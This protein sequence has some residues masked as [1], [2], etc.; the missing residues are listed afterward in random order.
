[1]L[2]YWPVLLM[3]KLAIFFIPVIFLFVLPGCNKF[4]YSPYQTEETHDDLPQNLNNSNISKLLQTEAQADDTVTFLYAG[5]SQRFYEELDDLVFKVN[6]IPHVDFFILCG[7]MTDFGIIKEYQ[8]IYRGLGKL[9]VPYMC[10][11]GNHDLTGGG[12]K[13]YTSMFGVKNFSF[14]YKTYKFIFHDTNS[15]EYGFNGAV[16]DINWLSSELADP[17]AGWF[18]GVSHVPPYDSD[19]DDALE[20]PYRTLFAD[21]SNFVVSLHGHTHMSSD[22]YVYNDGIRYMTCNAVQKRE[23]TLLKL[24][25]GQIIK[26]I[27]TY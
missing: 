26:Q 3:K 17:A 22:D 6:S 1:M 13:I 8:W 12:E 5:D 27:V 11:I 20:T 19:F 14:T 25:N 24:I 2:M 10:A 16:P 21:K 9:S 15:R 18:V 23:L 7:D 4:E